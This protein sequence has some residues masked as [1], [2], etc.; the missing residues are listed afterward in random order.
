MEPSVYSLKSPLLGTLSLLN[1]ANR[2]YRTDIDFPYTA[3]TLSFMVKLTAAIT[4][5]KK[6]FLS[7][8]FTWVGFPICWSSHLSASSL[9]FQDLLNIF[10]QKSSVNI[11]LRGSALLRFSPVNWSTLTKYIVMDIQ[12]WFWAKSSP[13]SSYWA[14]FFWPPP[15]IVGITYSS[16]SSCM[17]SLL[18]FLPL[19][20]N[21]SS[22]FY[23]SSW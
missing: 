14:P 6:L 7:A 9:A 12:F 19:W 17:S 22:I 18:G 13:Y 11:S 2:V 23:S 15:F 1:L 5:I 21:G 10:I 3:A 16:W 20:L 4:A 8:A